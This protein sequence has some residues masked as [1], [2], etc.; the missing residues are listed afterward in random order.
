MTS[1]VGITDQAFEELNA[2]YRW[3]ATHRS[4]EQA[5]LWYNGFLGAIKSLGDDAGRW[6]LAAENDDFPFEIRQLNYGVGRRATH[7]A[8][9]TIRPDLVLVIRI[10][11]L[12]QDV[13]SA[14]D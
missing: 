13:I 14:D 3:W 9:F 12:S 2:A 1:R 7:R 11:H 5:L 4:P 6:P 8:V 10:R